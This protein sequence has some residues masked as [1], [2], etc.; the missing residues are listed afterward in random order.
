MN[1]LHIPRQARRLT[2]K[3]I[4]IQNHIDIDPHTYLYSTNNQCTRNTHNHTHQTYM[5]GVYGINQNNSDFD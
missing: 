3:C 1:S 5:F 2:L 4:I